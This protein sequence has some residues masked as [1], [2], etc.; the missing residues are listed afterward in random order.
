[1]SIFYNYYYLL[2]F[3]SWQKKVSYEKKLVTIAE[4]VYNRILAKNGSLSVKKNSK[5]TIII[6][7]G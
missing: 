7:A 4:N 6:Y 2:E 1:M 5:K 3:G